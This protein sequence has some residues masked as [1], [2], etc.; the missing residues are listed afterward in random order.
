MVG[1]GVSRVN[2]SSLLVTFEIFFN[3]LQ[4]Y[5]ATAESIK[6][7]PAAAGLH[8][9]ALSLDL[10]NDQLLPFPGKIQICQNLRMSVSDSAVMGAHKHSSHPAVLLRLKVF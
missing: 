9:G 6:N 1:T 4:D 7:T 2:P 3:T 5:L 8:T 10:N